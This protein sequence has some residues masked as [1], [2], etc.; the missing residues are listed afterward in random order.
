MSAISD[1]IT[2]RENLSPSFE[3]SCLLFKTN[4]LKDNVD[5]NTNTKKIT[6][7]KDMTTNDYN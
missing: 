2:K 4:P 7:K 3:L 6:M 5:T 1:C